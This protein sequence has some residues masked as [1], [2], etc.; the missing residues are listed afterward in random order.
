MAIYFLQ[1]EGESELN[2]KSSEGKDNL[3][4]D[5]EPEEF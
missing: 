2:P 1:A 3:P 5:D 4:V